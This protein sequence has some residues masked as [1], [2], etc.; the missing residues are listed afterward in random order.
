MSKTILVVEDDNILA[1]NVCTYLSRAG[2]DAHTCSSGE[3]AL[4]LFERLNP[5]ALV[6]DHRLPRMSGTDLLRKLH[7][8]SRVQPLEQI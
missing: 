4:D 3:E 7:E 5:A 8:S 2:W 1:T 6:S